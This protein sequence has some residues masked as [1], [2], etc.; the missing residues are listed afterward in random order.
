[1]VL[2]P[3]SRRRGGRPNHPRRTKSIVAP[4]ALASGVRFAAGLAVVTGAA[5]AFAVVFRASLEAMYLR[6]YGFDNIVDSIAALPR[7]LRLMVPIA[8]A[9]LAGS[10]ARLRTPHAHGVSNVMEAIALGRAQSR[11]FL[12]C[13]VVAAVGAAA[14]L[15]LWATKRGSRCDSEHPWSTEVGRRQHPELAVDQHHHV[16]C[17]VLGV[18]GANDRENASRQQRLRV[19]EQ[20]FDRFIVANL[21]AQHPLRLLRCRHVILQ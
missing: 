13:G 15:I 18:A 3:G 11:Q 5:A 8:A 16:S 1:M 17:D 2:R 9:L 14:P 20:R 21:Y 4:S 12:E 10:L 6:L 19:P 7:W